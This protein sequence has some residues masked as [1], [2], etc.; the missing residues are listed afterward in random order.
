[1]AEFEQKLQTFDRSSSIAVNEIFDYLFLKPG[2]RLRPL[3]LLTFAGLVGYDHRHLNYACAIELIHNATLAHDDV[4]DDSKLRRGRPTIN[5]KYNNA[6]SVLFG[7]YLFTKAIKIL[8]EDPDDQVTKSLVEYFIETIRIMSEGEIKQLMES[9]SIDLNEANYFDIIYAKTSKLIELSCIL[10]PLVKYKPN[11]PIT[12]SCKSYGLHLGNAFQIIDDVIDYISTSDAMGKRDGDDFCEGKVT[13]PLIRFFEVAPKDEQELVKG[14]IQCD[15]PQNR[16]DHFSEVK[17]LLNKAH[18]FDY[19][20][21]IAKHEV[22]LAKAALQ[23]FSDQEYK[24]DLI[25]IADHVLTRMS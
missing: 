22:E 4:V 6:A 10:A 7:D 12:E 17:E 23:Q 9:H 18:C 3:L 15:D 20:K 8:L 16:R 11:H 25:N 1:M 14:L 24:T 21:E 19:C 2:K 5:A 13:L